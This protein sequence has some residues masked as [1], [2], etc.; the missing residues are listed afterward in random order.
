MSAPR[1]SC[2]ECMAQEASYRPAAPQPHAPH[3]PDQEYDFL[4]E[5]ARDFFCAVTLELLLDPHQTGCC[6]HHLSSGVVARL[7]R[8]GKPC[9]MC[10]RPNFQTHPDLYLR[11][12]VRE[13]R[14]RCP[15]TAGGC[16]W[17]GELGNKDAHT[18]RCP[19]RLPPLLILCLTRGCRGTHKRL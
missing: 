2:A 14:V 4:E 16:G 19:W 9:P 7:Q 1:R 8:E 10:Q 11:R 6:G 12:K 18:D 3:S 17:E 13:L 5:P 15:Y